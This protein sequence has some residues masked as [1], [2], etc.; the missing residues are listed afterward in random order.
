M[1]HSCSAILS[2]AMV[3]K[4]DDPG[5]FIISYTIGMHKFE[6]G[7]CDLVLISLDAICFIS[8]ARVGYSYIQHHETPYGGSTN[9]KTRGVLFDV[10][11]K[12][13]WFII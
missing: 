3:K 11:V 12:V 7:L 9:K 10:L 8:K 4:K 6:K 1:R 2:N 5:T 13:E